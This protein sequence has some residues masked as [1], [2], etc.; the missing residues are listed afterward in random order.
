MAILNGTSKIVIPAGLVGIALGIIF[1]L[2]AWSFNI[3][4]DWKTLQDHV[5]SKAIHESSEIKQARIDARHALLN[6][7]V[8][9]RLD[10]MQ[11]TLKRIENRIND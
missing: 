8:I 3:G 11:E 2:V 1:S 6:A 7:P 4:G 9:E 10:N 5:A